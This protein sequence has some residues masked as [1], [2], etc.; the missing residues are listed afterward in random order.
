MPN[1]G[2]PDSPLA[3]VM[4]DGANLLPS[5]PLGADTLEPEVPTRP[6]LRILTCW[7]VFGGVYLTSRVFVFVIFNA[8]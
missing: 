6:A 7:G 2:L 5:L 1:I 3:A 8:S 4:D